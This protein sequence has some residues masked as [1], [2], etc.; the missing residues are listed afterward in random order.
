LR[1]KVVDECRKAKRNYLE[2][3][4]DKNKKFPKRMWGTLREML[5]GNSYSDNIYEEIQY[6]DILLNN[7][8][9]MVNIFNKYLVNN[10]SLTRG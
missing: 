9:E 1:N 4:L 10:I 6:D 2:L 8:C 7:I 3:R 5:K